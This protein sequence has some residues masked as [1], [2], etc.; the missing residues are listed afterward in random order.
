[1]WTDTEPTTTA[2]AHPVHAQNP[3]TVLRWPTANVASWSDWEG[4]AAIEVARVADGHAGAA[5][6]Y[7]TVADLQLVDALAARHS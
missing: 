7:D 5:Y 4:V 3:A 2:D 6:G 1:V